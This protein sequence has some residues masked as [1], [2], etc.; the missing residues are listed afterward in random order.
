M[1]R[2]TVNQNTQSSRIDLVKSLFS[3]PLR[4]LVLHLVAFHG[5]LHGYEIMKRIE[6]L[7]GGI[8]KPSTSTLYMV[9]DT[10]VREGLLERREEYTGKRRRVKYRVTEKGIEVLRSTLDIVT[11]ILYKVIELLEELNG[12]FRRAKPGKEVL[13]VE[14][15][16]KQLSILKKLRKFIDEKIVW[17][18]KE[19]DKRKSSKSVK[20]S[21]IS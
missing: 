21:V 15:L 2:N 10:L 4:T 14:D 5:E 11:R 13:T 3:V 16:E 17:L 8:W 1:V 18:E 9:L 20:K 19:I 12:R 6:E 7:T